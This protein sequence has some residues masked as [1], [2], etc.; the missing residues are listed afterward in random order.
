VAYVLP[1]LGVVVVVLLAACWT[2]GG[3]ARRAS[4]ILFGLSGVTFAWL[5]PADPPLA[6]GVAALIACVGGMRLV[7][8]RRSA[9]SLP[10][11]IAHVA[12]FVDTRRM[13]RVPARIDVRGFAA[14]AVWTVVAFWLV[15][16]GSCLVVVYAGV[17][18]GY[19][20]TRAGY[21]A[22]GFETGPLH[23]APV[24]SRSVQELWG[25]RWARPV[26]RWLFETFFRPA[27][28][29]RHPIV[30]ALLAFTAS[31]VFHAYAV[32]VALGFSRG[33]TMTLSMLAYF[34]VQ[35]IVMALERAVGVRKW[36]P[37][38]GHVWTVG[39]MLATAP[40][41]LEPAVRL[42]GAGAGE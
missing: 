1:N 40:L 12:S 32:W 3:P 39:W 24:L 18:G 35:G 2:T 25:E 19:C 37:A 6:R 30:G 29:R 4:G 41:F 22:L 20:M 31:A 33:V 14:G 23:M 10:H 13:L 16:W 28:R 8:L 5:M 36:R 42:L 38:A 21:A 17:S 26:S 9:W 15:R 27:A 7:D 11:R 34:V